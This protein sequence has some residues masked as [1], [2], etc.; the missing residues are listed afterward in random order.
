[1]TGGDCI[2]FQDDTKRTLCNIIAFQKYE[3]TEVQKF[4]EV[5]IKRASRF[6]R[7]RSFTTKLFG[8]YMFSD[9]GA[10]AMIKNADKFFILKTGIHNEDQLAEFMA[11]E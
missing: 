7:L 10:E 3:R 11:K 8:R 2:F 1:M 4:R 9:M 5:I 6:S